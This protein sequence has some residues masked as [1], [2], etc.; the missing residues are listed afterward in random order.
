MSSESLPIHT[1]LMRFKNDKKFI[2][3]F[4]KYNREIDTDWVPWEWCETEKETRKNNSLV[5]FAPSHDTLHAVKLR[6]DHLNFQ[7]TQLY[8]NLWYTDVP[9][10][11][12]VIKYSQFSLEPVVTPVTPIPP[13]VRSRY[14]ST[15]HFC[16]QSLRKVYEKFNG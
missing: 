7:R 14:R 12:P 4:W 16:K 15:I 9:F 8:G 5:M 3:E 11:L 13:V 2:N 10:V 1:H 6:Y